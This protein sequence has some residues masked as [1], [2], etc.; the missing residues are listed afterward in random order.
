MKNGQL[1]K[2]RSDRVTCRCYR[3]IGDRI[4][5]VFV[6]LNS[7]GLFLHSALDPE[8]PGNHHLEQWTERVFFP[9]DGLLWVRQ[10]DIEA[11]E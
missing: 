2:I 4:I 8:N 9:G 11:L 7:V 5:A 3:D 6:S 10:K 1:I